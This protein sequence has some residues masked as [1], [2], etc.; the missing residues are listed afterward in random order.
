V[1]RFG[2]LV[3][4]VAAGVTVLWFVVRLVGA[5]PF[6]DGL[7][8]VTWPAVVAT[9]IL[10]A[11]TTLCSA[12]RWR[13]VARALGID[14]GLRVATGAYYRSL[15]LN[16]VLIGG[17]IGDVHRAVTHGRRAG[18]VAR[19][20]RAVGWERLW[21]QVIQAAVTAVVL[22][23]VASP[24]RP[25][26][27]YILAGIAAV[28]AVAGCAALAMRGPARRARSRLTRTVGA[29]WDDLR[30]GLLAASVWPRLTLASV[31]VVA[32]HTATFV[33][34]ARTAGATTPLAELV[35]LLLVIQTAVVIPLSIGGWGPREGAAAWAFA[36]AGLGAATGVTIATLYAVLMLIAVTPGAALL[37]GDALHRDRGRGPGHPHES[38]RPEPAPHP[39]ESVRG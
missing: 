36:A 23:T 29:V 32:G 25:A 12:W 20:V 8:A 11:V 17:I 15:F 5:A 27:P 38:T 22:L 4:R 35:A 39:L 30:H 37:L 31:L 6:V 14:I 19:G 9:I 1:R 13:V 2:P 24:V 33:I 18:D 21:G 28:A 34:A 16:S 10:T 7:R 26:L 3:L